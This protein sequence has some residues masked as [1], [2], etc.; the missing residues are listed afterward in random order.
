MKTLFKQLHTAYLEQVKQRKIIISVSNGILY[1]SKRVIFAVHRQEL[2][3]AKQSLIDIERRINKLQKDFGY[4]RVTDEGAYNAATEEY[5]EAKTFYWVTTGQSLKKIPKVKLNVNSYLGGL[6][7]L[8]GELVRQAT[9]AA[10]KNDY[11]TAKKNNQLINDVLAELIQFDMT[12][13]LRNK[14][15]QA[16]QHL[17]KIEEINYQLSLK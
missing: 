3:T 9:N 16:R 10:A 12:G 17:R 11:E 13:Y 6:S 2:D 5:V 8:C 7:D 15:D 4:T 14:Y 1:D